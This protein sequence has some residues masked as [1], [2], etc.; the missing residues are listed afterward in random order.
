MLEDRIDML[1]D[2]I[3]QGL[4]IA[5]AVSLHFVQEFQDS[6]H[7][8]EDQMLSNHYDSSQICSDPES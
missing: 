8:W 1:L 3:G 2:V 7:L 4:D 5:L 6:R